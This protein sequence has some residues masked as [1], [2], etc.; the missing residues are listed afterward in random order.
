MCLPTQG[1]FATIQPGSLLILDRKAKIVATLTNANT[2]GNLDSPWDLTIQDEGNVAKVFVS[3]VV[4]GTVT[5]LYLAIIGGKPVVMGTTH[6][7]S[8][9]TVQ[10]N[11]AAVILGPTGLAYD[12]V[13][14]VLYVAS[15][16]DNAIFAV[17]NARSRTAPPL[18]GTGTVIFKDDHLRGPLALALAPNGDLITS[19]GDAVNADVNQPS[20]IVEFTNNWNFIGEFNVDPAQGGAFGIAVEALG[21]NQA[22]FAA[23]DDN[24]NDISVY[25]LQTGQ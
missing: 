21:N 7:A 1:T 3:N 17:P 25:T 9:Y 11:T 12:L 22:R 18:N 23:V 24:T 20:E 6:I 15:T 8:G 4:S 16:A 2:N 10:P 13:K 14:D 19:N 5:R